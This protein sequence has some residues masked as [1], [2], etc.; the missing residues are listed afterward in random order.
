[1]QREIPGMAAASQL[2]AA[3][4]FHEAVHEASNP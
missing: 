2:A 1:M 4:G 3:L